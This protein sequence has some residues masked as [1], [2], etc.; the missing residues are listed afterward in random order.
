[1]YNNMLINEHK[2]KEMI[3]TLSHTFTIQNLSDIERVDTHELLGMYV[4]RYLTWNN[5][6]TCI[7]KRANS[8]LH[9]LRQ[10][11]RAAVSCKDMLRFYI[12]DIRPVIEY[13][14]PV[15]HTGLTAELAES[16][17]SVQKRALRI[18]FGRSSFTNSRCLSFRE[19][20]AVSSLQ[21][22]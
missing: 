20:L 6:L 10:L 1:M 13:A 3:V 15:W 22:V 8:R 21:S 17:E 16:L 5:H 11:K 14:A 18:I 19:S 9:F 7:Y 12:A 2:T 4:S